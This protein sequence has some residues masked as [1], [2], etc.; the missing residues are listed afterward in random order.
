MIS[1]QGLGSGLDIASIVSQL[2]A[3]EGQPTTLR[4]TRREAGIQ[5][6]LSALGSLKSAL[7]TFKDALT[8]L[9]DIEVFRSRSATSSDNDLFTVTADNTAVQSSYDVEVLSLATSH[10]IASQAFADVDADIGEGTLVITTG[11][12]PTD[13]FAVVFEED[14]SSLAEIRDA[15]NQ[16][17][18]NPGI[19]AA[20]VNGEDGAHLVL[21]AT[22]TGVEHEIQITSSGGAGALDVF[23]YGIGATGSTMTELAA[24]QDASILVDS[25]AHSSGNNSITGVI[26]GVTL[27]L[28]GAAP[29][30]IASL[31]VTYDVG[32]A[33]AKVRDFVEGYNALVDSLAALSSYNAETGDAG[34]LL[35][36]T[37]LREVSTAVRR[38]VGGGGIQLDGTFATLSS[39][40]VTTELDGKL[41][42]DE[43]QLAE[44]LNDDFDSV[45]RLFADEEGFATRLDAILTPF[46]ETGGRID[47]RTEGLETSI[48]LIE[49]QRRALDL[50]LASIEARYLRQFSALDSIISELTTTSNFLAQ[51]LAVLPT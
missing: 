6:E 45:G 1:A 7:S 13:T 11:S 21:T 50:R 29:G 44:R 22:R 16:S 3:A 18:L 31:D 27:N 4:L 36:D 24:A 33:T 49:E 5:A 23:S 30:T 41:T 17:D 10:K 40:G 38:A 8:P 14:A 28:T 48:E 46:T 47:D 25:F 51:Q 19:G 15:I 26:D 9:N 2:V 12:E 43:T 42:I 39:I 20:I 34:A 32:A 37:S 35:G